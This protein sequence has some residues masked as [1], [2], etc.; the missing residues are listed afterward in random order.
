MFVKPRSLGSS[1]G[2]S[3]VESRSEL[4]AS[5]E[6]A[7]V[8]DS[9]ALVEP[10]MEGIIEI[11]CAVLG[12][13]TAA[14]ASV[15]EQPLAGGVLSYADKYLTKGAG[16]NAGMKGSQRIIPAQLPDTLTARIQ[17]V[18]VDAFHA[19]DAEGVARVDFLVRPERDELVVNEINTVP[20]SLSFYLWERSGVPFAELVTE[21]VDLAQRRHAAKR[22]TTYSIDSWLLSGVPPA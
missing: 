13:A 21:L 14:R 6:L 1:I 20:G 12:N 7:L 22:A 18:A 17:Q 5:L 19:I 11:N 15:C 3:R 9:R 16:K 2:V 10:A 8:Y 4:E